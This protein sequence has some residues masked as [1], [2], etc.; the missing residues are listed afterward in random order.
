MLPVLTFFCIF[1]HQSCQLTVSS[2]RVV[3][4]E[5]SSSVVFSQIIFRVYQRSICFVELKCIVEFLSV[6][7]IQEL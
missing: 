6:A 4:I 2:G 5:S 1:F 7:V 3:L